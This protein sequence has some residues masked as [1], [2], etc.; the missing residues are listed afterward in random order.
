MNA[1]LSVTVR[2]LILPLPGGCSIEIL[3]DGTA[4][5]EVEFGETT[6]VDVSPGRHTIALLLH[7]LVDRISQSESLSCAAGET[8]AVTAKYSRLWGTMKL[9][10]S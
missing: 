3:V 8:V 7:G 6:T 5:G 10:T 4:V 2:P 9:Q 1:H